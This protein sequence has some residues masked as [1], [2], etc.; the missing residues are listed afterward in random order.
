MSQIANNLKRLFGTHRI[1]VWTDEKKEHRSEFETIALDGIEKVE[2]QN[3]EFGLKYR[4]LRQEQGQKFLLYRE[5]P[6]PAYRDNWLLDVELAHCCFSADLISI[7]LTE[8]G[9]NPVDFGS[10]ATEHADFF[11]SEDRCARLKRLRPKEASVNSVR[12]K[13][14][15]A[16]ARVEDQLDY[17][18]EA[19]LNELAEG[20]ETKIKDIQRFGL[21]PFLWERTARQYGY[22]PAGDQATTNHADVAPAADEAAAPTVRDFAIELFQNAYCRGVGEPAKL[23]A[24]AVVFLKRWQDNRHSQATFETLSAQC[25]DILG[26]Q[27][28]LEARTYQDVVDLDIFELI[29]RKIL[30][31]LVQDVAN[32]TLS[33]GATTQLI[34]QRRQSHWYARYRHEYETIDLGARFLEML[35]AVELTITSLTQGIEQYSQHWYKLD[36]LY[37]GVIYHSRKSG[38]ITLLGPLLEQVENLYSNRFL[39]HLNNGWQQWVDAADRWHAPGILAQQDFFDKQVR[40]FL[41]DGNKVF[42]IISDALRYEIGEELA[43]R[44]RQEDR[45]TAS[46]QPAL[47]LL[48]S[49]T[50]LGMAAL[51]PHTQIE[52]DTQGS[53]TL[54]G[55]S[56]QGTANRK[57]ILAQQANAA[58]NALQ[59]ETFLE[60]NQEASRALFSQHDVVYIDHNRIDAVGDKRD[61]EERVF[62]AVAEALDEL[63]KII[64]KAVGANVTNFLVTADH[65]FIYQH[66]VL[67]ESEYAA[68]KPSGQQMLATNRRYVLGQGLNP[69]DSFKHF[70]AAAVGL[71]SNLEMLIPKSINRLRVRGAGSRYVHGGAALQE[72]VIPVV[73]IN[74]SRHSD[75]TQV[76][77]DILQSGNA[78]ISTGQIA[79]AFY[80]SVPV[81]D[82]IQARTLRA[83]LYTEEGDLISDQHELAFDLPSDNP[84]EREVRVQF[85]LTKAADNANGQEVLLKLEEP[86][87]GT[88]RYRDYKSAR[89]MLRRSFTSDFDF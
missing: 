87:S 69:T 81:T 78:V 21:V 32:R 13:M 42:V 15:A 86:I 63:V 59:A 29:D 36:Q 48:P 54:D 16:C 2:I 34:R 61:S 37:R 62:E 23:H 22:R 35:A 19:L 67:D 8:L 28:A 65:G 41:Q 72:V 24:D 17:I 51:L 55:Q 38:Q 40:P 83:G 18:L 47:T 31:E 88:S 14:V 85:V 46:I 84:R 50:Q 75:I 20:K 10:L 44:I 45:Y 80:Q 60:M 33:A 30:P 7:R 12:L 64:K 70:N 52:I 25:A 49:Y 76:D 26:I 39:L 57:K 68:Q 82:K 53:I 79:V 66:N 74:K 11:S 1:I 89:Y 56:P 58:T 9:L 43:R 27:Q 3:N 71:T 77:V 4:I 73:Q 5:G 6:K